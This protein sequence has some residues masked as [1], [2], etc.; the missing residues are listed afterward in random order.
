MNNIVKQVMQSVFDGED[1]TKTRWECMGDT[2]LDGNHGL[3]MQRKLDNSEIHLKFVDD[4]GNQIE[5]IGN[6]YAK[7]EEN[8]KDNFH[9]LLASLKFV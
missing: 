1:H 6:N 5:A 7:A 8:L 9:N 3:L 2:S 4:S